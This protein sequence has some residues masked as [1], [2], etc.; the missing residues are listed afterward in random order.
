MN[1]R[2]DKTAGI[3]ILELAR[4]AECHGCELVDQNNEILIRSKTKAN[5]EN[6][7]LVTLGVD[8]GLSLGNQIRFVDKCVK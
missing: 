2:I 3:R 4:F 1:I 6:T 5:T 8:F 7:K